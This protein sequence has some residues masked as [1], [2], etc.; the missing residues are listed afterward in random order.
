M[1]VDRKMSLAERLDFYSIPEPNSGC[2]LWMAKVTPSGH[3]MLAW[4]R[5]GRMA[6]R[7]AWTVHKGPIP[8]GICVCHKCDVPSCINVDHLFLGSTQ[9]NTA[10]KMRKGRHRSPKGSDHGRSKLTNEQ[11]IA[12]RE[13]PRDMGRIAW[14]YG[15]SVASIS[16]IRRRRIWKHL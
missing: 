3:G 5:Q 15:V 7:L 1:M 12:I 4:H 13:D 14:E 10:D 9:D 11:V 2:I 16:L 8:E 6:H